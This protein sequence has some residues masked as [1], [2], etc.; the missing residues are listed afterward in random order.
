VGFYAS[1]IHI[2]AYNQPGVEAGKKAASAVLELQMRV[3][4]ALSTAPRNAEE[5]ASAV[6]DA[7]AAETVYFILEQLAADGRVE[8]VQAGGPDADAFRRLSD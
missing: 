4:N 6:G 3:L 8:A 5:I 2:N 1:L 7:S